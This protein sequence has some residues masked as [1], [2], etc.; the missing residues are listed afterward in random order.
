MMIEIE[1]EKKKMQ[2]NKIVALFIKFQWDLN[3]SLKWGSTMVEK[4]N[5]P[6]INEF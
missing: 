3:K 2:N 5:N 6:T 4:P 1:F